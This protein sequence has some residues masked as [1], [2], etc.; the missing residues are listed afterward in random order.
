MEITFIDD[1]DRLSEELEKNF[2]MNMPIIPR[3]GETITFNPYD[4]SCQRTIT[5]VNYEFRDG[6][7][8]GIFVWYVF[9]L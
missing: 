8:F 7:F 2:T 6:V 1:T 5:S 9:P 4:E 3:F